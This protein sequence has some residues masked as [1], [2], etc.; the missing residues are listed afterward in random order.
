MKKCLL[1]TIILKYTKTHS[2]DYFHCT[3]FL[4]RSRELKLADKIS[5]MA[6][7]SFHEEFLDCDRVEHTFR[8]VG[9]QIHTL[10]CTKPK[11]DSC[12]KF[13]QY[14]F[15]LTLPR[16]DLLQ[17]YHWYE[18]LDVFRVWEQS[19]YPLKNKTEKEFVFE[20]EYVINDEVVSTTSDV[21]EGK[22]AVL[23]L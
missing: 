22:Q 20:M 15:T 14:N 5:L 17:R 3:A 10:T 7:H 4:P 23:G 2:L 19:F 12:L 13:Q 9:T 6:L 21:V 16:G 11:T 1:N 8:Q 18:T